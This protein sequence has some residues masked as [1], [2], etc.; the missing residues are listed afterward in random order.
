VS[1]LT[2]SLLVIGLGLGVVLYVGSLFLQGYIYT[3]P[4]QGL[5][6]QAPAAAAILI[7]FIFFWTLLI[8]NSA[9]ASPTDIPYDALFRFN[10]YVDMV[11]QPVKELTAVH[12]DNKKL[13]YKLHK[14]VRFEGSTRAYY[15]EKKS[16]E[17][18]VTTPNW[19]PDNL[20]EI[21]ITHNGE[22][23]VFELQPTGTGANL[24]F[25]HSG[26]GY[27][28]VDY[29]DGPDGIPRASRW[30]RFLANLLL[31][32]FHLALWFVCLWLLLRFQWGHALGLGLV[33]WLLVTL[34][35]MP[36]LLDAAGQVAVDKRAKTGTKAA[37]RDDVGDKDKRPINS[38]SEERADIEKRS[39]R[40][41]RQAACLPI[42]AARDT[43]A[44]GAGQGRPWPFG[45]P[46]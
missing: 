17:R 41:P 24:E 38:R 35:F 42:E 37:Q 22:E 34:V 32:F 31:N 45:S 6:W 16:L 44:D 3:E 30:S 19:N 28:F 36:M 43:D 2:L 8:T 5:Y 14:E 26:T 21:R 13:V 9:T 27:T 18:G 1:T 23:M 12:K 7:V 15:V 25:V 4:S 29:G 39:Q 11:E 33:S 46:G 20:K 10:R 40:F